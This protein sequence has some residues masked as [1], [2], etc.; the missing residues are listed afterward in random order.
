[1]VIGQLDMS[2][3]YTRLIGCAASVF[4]LSA[5]VSPTPVSDPAFSAVRAVASKPLPINDGAIY[6]SGYEVALFEDTKARRVGDIITV[7]LS[8]NTNASIK[9]K[10]ITRKDVEGVMA[11]PT[12]LGRGITKAGAALFGGAL[13]GERSFKGQGDTSQR[14]LLT[15][16]ISVVISE[17]LPNGNLMIRG[18][19]LLT[20]NQGVEHIRVSGIV[21]PDDVTPDNTV[22]SAKIANAKILY[23]GQGALAESNSKGWLQ[24]I[25]DGPWWP[26]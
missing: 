6:K 23:G 20:L 19:K 7:I 13:D 4:V 1:M 9:A 16:T 5:C 10:T 17:V 2:A 18:E 26:F 8:E 15:G 22:Q 24:R 11:A 3:K 12:V 14:N 21:R 25:F